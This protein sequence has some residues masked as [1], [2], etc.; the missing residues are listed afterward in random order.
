[1]PDKLR[2]QRI[3]WT[4][5]LMGQL[6]FSGVALVIPHHPAQPDLAQVLVP[7]AYGL[8]IINGSLAFTLPSLLRRRA[9]GQPLSAEREQ[10]LMIMPLAM[11]EGAALFAIVGYLLTGDT[12]VLGAF[13][14]SLLL[15]LTCFPLRTHS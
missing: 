10:T 2:T 8:L 12:T 9:G 13:A 15:Y 7:I 5:L 1:M 11:I 3:I 6:I 14:I 4:A